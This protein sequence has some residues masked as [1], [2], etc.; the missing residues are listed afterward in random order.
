MIQPVAL[1]AVLATA[2]FADTAAAIPP[3]PP[4]PRHHYYGP[5]RVC[6]PGANP[7]YSIDVLP[8]E[9]VATQGSDISVQNERGGLSIERI[10]GPG[11]FRIL[12]EAIETLGEIPVPNAGIA[13]RARVE[14]S[15]R[16]RIDAE[17]NQ[18]SGWVEIRS[19][20][21][22][23]TDGDLVALKRIKFGPEARSA[24]ANVPAALAP[25]PERRD[26]LASWL[27]PR[28]HPGPFTICLDYLAFDVHAAETA[29][30]PWRRNFAMAL[31]EAGE[32]QVAV[33]TGLH[34]AGSPHAWTGIAG[35]VIDDPR[36][37]ANTWTPEPFVTNILLPRP[38]AVRVRL[39]AR[40]ERARFGPSGGA[41][42]IFS[43]AQSPNDMERTAVVRRLRARSP[44]D[45]CFDPD[46]I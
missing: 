41:G 45:Q 15:V 30:L 4:P 36:F 1:L 3:P 6:E 31:I 34:P 24:C 37:T 33:T 42:V 32:Q 40:S 19:S 22:D 28:R 11:V 9:A 25:T 14:G 18:Y 27:S 21:F 5:L 7:F 8:G 38:A 20:E 44:S 23:G 17:N 2:V 35:A 43:F 39:M 16:Y 10:A 12:P 46:R 13:Q 26:E 29:L